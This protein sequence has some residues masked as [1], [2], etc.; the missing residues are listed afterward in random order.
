MKKSMRLKAAAVFSAALL[1]TAGMFSAHRVYAF[2]TDK[3]VV[4][5]EAQIGFSVKTEL[6]ETEDD[7]R[8]YI[9]VKNTGDTNAVVRAGVF[10]G[11]F[12]EVG[13]EEADSG[14]IMWEQGTDEDSAFWYYTEVLVPGASTRPLIISVKEEEAPSYAFSVTAV[15]EAVRASYKDGALNMPEEWDVPE[16]FGVTEENAS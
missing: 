9:T 10:A 6:I 4:R 13:P 5:G 8:T 16:H 12:A 1:L 15:Q 14:R 2:I 11:A 3:A 7:G